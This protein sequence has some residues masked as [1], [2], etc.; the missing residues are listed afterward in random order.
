MKPGRMVSLVLRLAL[1]G[2]FLYASIDKIIHPQAFA[3]IIFNYHLLPDVL[4]NAA[5]LILPWLE[6]ILALFLIMGW[7][8]PGAVVLVNALLALFWAALLFNLARG[9]DINCGCFS[10]QDAGH[11]S[12][13]WYVIRDT[14]FLV[15]GSALF[16]LVTRKQGQT[17][18]KETQ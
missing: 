2:I 3:E 9:L 12:M 13:L 16:L 17:A 1:G 14:A 18:P 6:A 4:I 11:T 8:L 7:F 10:T 15:M 5:A